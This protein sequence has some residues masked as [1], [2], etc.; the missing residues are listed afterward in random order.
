MRDQDRGQNALF[1]LLDIGVIFGIFLKFVMGDG[2]LYILSV[3]G[4]KRCAEI[5][6]FG[7]EDG[8]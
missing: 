5:L 7:G 3:Q 1:T 6:F 8:A 4:I 2:P